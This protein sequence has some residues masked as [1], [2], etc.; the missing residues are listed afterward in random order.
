MGR[1]A[2]PLLKSGARFGRLVVIEADIHTA[3]C[4]CDCGLVKVTLPS[5]LRHG[6]CRSC[7]CLR[8]ERCESRRLGGVPHSG[9]QTPEY[10]TWCDMK[11]RC[12]NPKAQQYKWYGGRGITVCERWRKSFEAF[13]EDM[14][15]RP[16]PKHTLDRRDNEGPYSPE[17]CKW[18]TWKEQGRNKRNTKYITINGETRCAS[19]WAEVLGLPPET[20]YYRFIRMP[21][22]R[23]QRRREGLGERGQRLISA[24]G[25]ALTRKEW[26]ARSGLK[27]T[28]ITFRLKRGWDPALAVTIPA[29]TYIGPTA[30]A[31]RERECARG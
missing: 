31:D 23:E 30:R 18:S 17:N 8:R 1:P 19:E 10:R 22:K 21:A 24:N 4:L 27:A 3:A 16:S 5:S 26:A 9:K 6:Q 11:S 15:P 20:V 25:E 28:T 14:G 7:G 12:S 13:Y 2:L 29:G